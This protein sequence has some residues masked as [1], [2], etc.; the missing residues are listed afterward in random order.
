MVVV[1]IV[2]SEEFDVL[3][4]QRLQRL[5]DD[6]L[7]DAMFLDRFVFC[8]IDAIPPSCKNEVIG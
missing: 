8:P 6:L 5:G 7:D 2:F 4:Q 3:F 1:G